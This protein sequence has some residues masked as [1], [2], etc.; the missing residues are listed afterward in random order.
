MTRHIL[1]ATLGLTWLVVVAMPV[2]AF[3]EAWLIDAFLFG[4][5]EEFYLAPD[6]APPAGGLGASWAAR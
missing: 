1:I 4:V 2:G 3:V 6:L 5:P